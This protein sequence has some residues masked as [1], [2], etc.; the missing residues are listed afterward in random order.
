MRIL[1]KHNRAPVKAK[2][3]VTAEWQKI[4]W[5]IMKCDIVYVSKCYKKPGSAEHRAWG[6]G[7]SLL[8]RRVGT[9]LN[10]KET[11]HP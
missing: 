5:E 4:D 6:P 7:S 2:E 9:G 8:L 10:T 3:P 1:A 11:F